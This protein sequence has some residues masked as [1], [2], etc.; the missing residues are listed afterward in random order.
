[1][2]N[3]PT[4]ESL[5]FYT[6]QDVQNILKIGKSTAY[7]LFNSNCFPSTKIGGQFRI[8]KKALI[9]WCDTNAGREFNI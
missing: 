6:I 2:T 9:S 4:S 7:K 8:S 3:T 5:E 1:M